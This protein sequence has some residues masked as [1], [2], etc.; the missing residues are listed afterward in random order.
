[1]KS[2]LKNNRGLFCFMVLANAVYAA[3]TSVVPITA[4]II[5][6][7]VN[8]ST[9][10]ET[11]L[12]KKFLFISA[13]ELFMVFSTG[14]VKVVLKNGFLKNIRVEIESDL[15][16]ATQKSN[17]SLTSAVNMFSFEIDSIIEK[18][19]TYLGEIVSIIIPLAIALIYSIVVSWM[20][21]LVIAITFLVVIL[22]NQVLVMPLNNHMNSLSKSNENV[23][24]MLSGFLSAITSLRVY[25]GICYAFCHISKV[26]VERNKHEIKKENYALLIE[27]INCLFSTLLQIIPLAIIAIMVVNRRLNIG[28][29]LSI[30]LLFE[31]IVSPID[32]IST[33]RERIAETSGYRSK[34]ADVINK[35]I[36][37][38][39]VQGVKPVITVENESIIANNLCVNIGEKKIFENLNFCFEARKKYLIIGKNGS[40]KSTLL[41]VL[42]KQIEEYDGEIVFWGKSLKAY[43]E[44]ELFEIVGIIPQTIEIFDDTLLNNITLGKPADYSKL[45]NVL[46]KAGLREGRLG[47]H[48]TETLNNFSGGELQRIV[49]ARMF[50]YPKK[51]YFLDEVTSGLE[52]GL[53]KS[54]EETILRDADSTIVH[55][56]HRSDETIINRYDAIISMSSENGIKCDTE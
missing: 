50:Y 44:K 4:G 21:I 39:A 2:Y 43:S 54:I 14:I 33:M 15:F 31:K 23:N 47:E 41:K 36:D 18:Y 9:G 38:N 37:F 48:I 51:V 52:Y 17:V 34:I 12:I 22:I 53:A 35:G 19:Y 29:A 16:S 27:S 55:I 42:T 40:G 6:D 28:A 45:K 8:T 26:L 25:G 56:S 46:Y 1:M 11:N 24:G 20:T 13:A 32:E 30:M 10:L 49:L 5:I 3:L 7:A